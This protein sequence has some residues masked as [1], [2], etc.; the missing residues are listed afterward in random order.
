MSDESESPT[1]RPLCRQ[2]SRS[3]G[4][5]LAGPGY[6]PVLPN[7]AERRANAT[8]TATATAAEQLPL[9]WPQHQSLASD[10]VL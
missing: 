10:D 9:I 8:A 2:Q 5:L 7:C 6:S 4:A 1:R 3:S